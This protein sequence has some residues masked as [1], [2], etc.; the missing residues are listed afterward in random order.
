MKMRRL[1]LG[2]LALVALVAL[3]V[4]AVIFIHRE[5]EKQREAVAPPQPGGAYELLFTTPQRTGMPPPGSPGRLD[6]RLVQ[7]VDGAQQSVDMA[8]YDFGLDSV[9]DALLR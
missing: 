6:E 1:V 4:A 9:A 5:E 7:L 2:G 3:V 8:I